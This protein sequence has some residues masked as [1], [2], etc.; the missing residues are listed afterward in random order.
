[1]SVEVEQDYLTMTRL[2]DLTKFDV[3]GL[4]DVTLRT[5]HFL[6]CIWFAAN[7]AQRRKRREV[8]DSKYSSGFLLRAY[9]P[10]FIF[11]FLHGI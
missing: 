5:L 8:F 3:T 11:H 2:N 7:R 1:M 6:V 9:S 4:V 10:R